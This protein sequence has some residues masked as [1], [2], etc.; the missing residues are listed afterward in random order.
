VIGEG[1]NIDLFAEACS[2]GLCFECF[3]LIA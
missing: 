2:L 1:T 3:G